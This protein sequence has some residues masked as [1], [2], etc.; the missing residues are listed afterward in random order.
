MADPVRVLVVDD[1]A[2]VRRAVERMLEDGPGIRVVGGAGNGAE[3]V[4]LV[5]HLEP[6]VVILD[7]NM[8]HLDGLQALE[9]II[10]EAPTGVLMLS[11]LTT[12]GA[13]TTVRALE[14]GAVDFLDK[15][16]AG[17]SM[18]IY[19]MAPMLRE[20]VLAVA[21][22]SLPLKAPE[23]GP[24]EDVP[25]GI[26]PGLPAT[27]F[28]VVVIGTS[29]GGP[30]ALAEVLSRLPANFPVGI[31]I[32]QHMPPGFTA[33]LANRLDRRSQLNVREAQDHDR[34]VPGLVLLAPGGMQITLERRDGTLCVRVAES[35]AELLHR[36]S[37]DVLFRSVAEVVGPGAVG[38]V[39]TGMGDDGAGGLQAM[40]A[41]GAAT[42]AESQDT[43]VIY[44]MPRAAAPAA[45]RIVSLGR[46][47]SA[48]V[49]TTTERRQT[50]GPE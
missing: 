50:E 17:S 3:A 41:A 5:K 47:A 43:A 45:D 7:V 35:T 23:E 24:G 18:D 31:V 42:M 16:L 25:G 2:F 36:P 21:G 30:R 11:T 27:E 6:D 26:G 38:V 34:V 39:L 28:E 48:L 33:T 12:E 37:V 19:K 40:K 32:A 15:G 20:K 10:A 8:P 14:L 1:S 9:R 4:S 13:Q 29:T 22:A 46:V 49:K 44:G